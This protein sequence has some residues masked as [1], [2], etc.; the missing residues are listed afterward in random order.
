[1][2]G[3]RIGLIICPD[4][5]LCRLLENE[6]DYFGIPSVSVSTAQL[7]QIPSPENRVLVLL[8]DCDSFPA[9]EGICAARARECPILLFGHN[10]LEIPQASDPV[11]FLRRPFALSEL[12]KALQDLT[13]DASGLR[14]PAG[15]PARSSVPLAPSTP[16]LSLDDK[17]GTVRTNGRSISLTPAEW[18]IFEC[19]YNHRGDV[20]PRETLASL[21]GGGGNSA[22]VYVC[23][24]RTKI[25]KPLGRR[26][27]HTVRGVGYRL[28]ESE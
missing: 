15:A 21:L 10:S 26:M 16:L 11:R 12:E 28:D 2:T 20:V 4:E 22:D 7:P 18:A 1:M 19:L 23:H 9:D 13:A 27:I 25:E 24:L 6:L 17:P 5:R 3:N 8:W 14:S